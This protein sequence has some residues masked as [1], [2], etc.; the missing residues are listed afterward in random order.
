MIGKSGKILAV[1]L[2]GLCLSVSNAYASDASD[3]YYSG[4]KAYGSKDYEGAIK[5]FNKSANDGYAP[6][7][8]RLGAMLSSG[9]GFKRDDRKAAMWFEKAAKQGYDPAV[10]KLG[11]V[12]L[13]G[14]GVKRDLAEAYTWFYKSA[15]SGNTLAV[16]K[17]RET[18]E[19]MDKRELL[20]VMRKLGE[21][22]T[23]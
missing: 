20:E 16:E 12:Y 17:K 2:F 7:Q 9:R 11:L 8:Y 15:K 19:Q 23:D 18:A 6:A 13:S 5:W 1:A 3:M 14:S 21:V 4:V 10:Y 22:P